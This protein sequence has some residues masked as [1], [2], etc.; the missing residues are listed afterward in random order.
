MF[1]GDVL[2]PWILR[3]TAET[4]SLVPR[5]QIS[6]IFLQLNARSTSY[7]SMPQ[8]LKDVGLSPLVPIS[9]RNC[10]RNADDPIPRVPS[11]CLCLKI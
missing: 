2:V 6:E 1:F 8:I 11:M 10:L 7:C 4:G 5:V 9:E 3:E